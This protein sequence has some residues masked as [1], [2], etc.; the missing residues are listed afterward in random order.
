MQQRSTRYLWV[1]HLV[2]EEVEW[3]QIRV[4]A[5]QVIHMQ[6]IIHCFCLAWFC[7]VLPI[8][9]S[10]H[11][12]VSICTTGMDV[13]PTPCHTPTYIAHNNL[14]KLT[15][16]SFFS[17]DAFSFSCPCP[18]L[19]DLLQVRKRLGHPI[20]ISPSCCPYTQYLDNLQNS[21]LLFVRFFTSIHPSCPFLCHS[22]SGQKVAG[23]R[24][25]VVQDE[26]DYCASDRM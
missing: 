11:V 12:E 3:Y 7:I 13:T 5:C 26:E 4:G 17:T 18:T 23:D 15:F 24:R 10:H 16:A 25:Q 22:T 1:E 21:P 8:P 19:I 2:R 20:H 6:A 9:F 14:R